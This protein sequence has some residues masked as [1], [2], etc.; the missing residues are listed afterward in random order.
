MPVA[1]ANNL[2]QGVTFIDPLYLP[3]SAVQRAVNVTFRGLSPKTRPGYHARSLEADNPQFTRSFELGY[4]QGAFELRPDAGPPVM[5]LVVSGRIFLWDPETG[6]IIRQDAPQGPM[7]PNAER[8]W[9][10]QRGGEL[11]IQDGV[12]RPRIVVPGN[13]R[14][15]RSTAR[16]VPVGTSMA[17]GHGRLSVAS[18]HRRSFLSGDHELAVGVVPDVGLFTFTDTDYFLG[19]GAMQPPGEFGPIVGQAYVSQ[20]DTST[21]VGALVVFSERGVSAYAT[22]LPRTEWAAKDIS[23]AILPGAN[24]GA[25]SP[26]AIVAYGED[27]FYLSP[28]GLKSVRTA[29]ATN[30]P[31]QIVNLSGD[32]YPIWSATGS[33]LRR[34]SSMVAHDSRLLYTVG[35]EQVRPDGRPPRVVFRGLLA[36]NLDRLDG[37]QDRPIQDGLWTGLQIQRVVTVAGRA[38]AI[39]WYDDRNTIFEIDS[40]FTHDRAP[41]GVDRAIKSELWFRSEV[42]EA[43]NQWKRAVAAGV[44]IRSIVG[45]VEVTLNAIVDRYPRLLRWG[46]FDHSA[47]YRIQVPTAGTKDRIPTLQPHPHIR[48]R[49]GEPE[50]ASSLCDPVTGDRLAQ[51][52]ELQPVLV[53]EGHATFGQLEIEGT[54][55][56]RQDELGCESK[57]LDTEP[58]IALDESEPSLYTY[59]LKTAKTAEVPEYVESSAIAAN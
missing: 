10:C 45:R 52:R 2:S 36:Y 51:F 23:L 22:N 56:S 50:D 18:V 35:P 15:S 19:G 48:R 28:E 17:Q 59:Q 29:R 20:Y 41:D 40:A 5:V 39:A 25:L 32:V 44:G 38:F 21:G 1:V 7:A 13:T 53:W 8:V 4:L 43:V 12:N 42:F 24:N 57:T 9:G 14:I 47:G 3:E 16:E 27:L 34:F 54:I 6:V 26:D 55:V 46:S 31:H 11:V 49:F 58:P 37:R 30:L 33:S